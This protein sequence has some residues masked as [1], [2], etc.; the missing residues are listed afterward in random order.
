MSTTLRYWRGNKTDNVDLTSPAF[1]ED[2]TISKYTIIDKGV[3]ST[4]TVEVMIVN[5]DQETSVYKAIWDKG[6]FANETDGIDLMRGQRI[7]LKSTG[8]L[9]FNFSFKDIF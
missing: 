1:P 7:K 6:D 5:D 9:D 4:N 8:A 3:A 2:V